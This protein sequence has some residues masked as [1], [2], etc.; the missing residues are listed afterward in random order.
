MLIGSSADLSDTLELL[1]PQILRRTHPDWEK[2]SIDGFFFRC[3]V[4]R[5]RASA[6]LV[7]TCILISD[8]SGTPF[9]LDLHVADDG[10]LRPLGLRLGEQGGGPLG[11]SGPGAT[12]APLAIFWMGSLDGW[13]GSSGHTTSRYDE[14]LAESRADVDRTMPQMPQKKGPPRSIKR[15]PRFPTTGCRP[16]RKDR[17]SWR[18]IPN[19]GDY[20]RVDP[21]RLPTRRPR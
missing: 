13:I 11:I 17:G 21:R 20:L 5:G 16:T 19:K 12:H 1:I 10:R 4:K 15:R 6:E 14:L 9:Q 2:E 8:Q 7:G 3:C 18:W